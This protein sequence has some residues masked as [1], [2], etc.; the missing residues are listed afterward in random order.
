MKNQN[1]KGVLFSL[2]I[3]IVTLLLVDNWNSGKQL[4][5]TITKTIQAE[6][7]PK[8]DRVDLAFKQEFDKTKDPKLGHVPRERLLDAREFQLQKFL[9]KENYKGSANAKSISNI[10]WTERGPDNVGGRTR[11]IMFDPNDATNKKVWAGGVS[12]GLWYNDDITNVNSSWNKVNDFLDNLAITVIVSDPNDDQTFYAGTGE[13]HFVSSVRGAGI[14]KTTD[15]GDTWTHM[16]ADNSFYATD[17]WHYVNDIVVRN[18]SGTSVV[19]V[20]TQHSFEVEFTQRSG[21]NGLFRSTDGGVNFT[22]VLPNMPSK[23]YSYIPADIEL[24][25]SNRL[26][27][28][29]TKGIAL[30]PVEYSDGGD[31]LYSDDGTTWTLAL[32]TSDARVELACAPSDSDII[33]AVADDGTAAGNDCAWIKKCDNCSTDSDS[34]TDLTVPAYKTQGTCANSGTQDFT[35]GQA[36]Y[37][38]ILA[39]HPADADIAII[40]GI[41]LYRTTNGSTFS[42]ISYWTGSCDDEVHADQHAIVFRPGNSDEVVIGCDGGIYYS[43]DAGDNTANPDFTAHNDGYNVTQFYGTAIHPTSGTNHFLAGAQDN[44]S[45]KF[46]SSGVNST[47]EVSGGDGAFC[48][49][50]QSNAN[51]QFTQYVYNV[52][53]RSTNGGS[54]FTNVINDQST[55]QFI[56][57]TDYDNDAFILYG[58]SSA[59]NYFRWNDP[60]TGTSTST[61]SLSTLNGDQVSAVTVDPNTSNRVYFGSDGGK[62]IVVDDA[63]GTPS[64]T[65]ISGGSFS[66]YVS[67]IE[68]EDGDAN[69]LLVTFS[70]YGVTSVW[71]STDAGSNWIAIE[72]DLPDMPVRWGIFHPLNSDMAVLATELGIWTTDDINGAGTAWESTN[73][74]LSNVR[75]DM[76]QVRAADN[77]VIAATHGRGLFSSSSF[78]VTPSSDPV[79]YFSSAT[80]AITEI[81]ETASTGGDCRPYKDYTVTMIIASAPTGD[82]T[83]TLSSSITT[84]ADEWDDFVFTTNGDFTQAGKSSTLTFSDGATTSQTFTVR[85]YDDATVENTETIELEFAISGTTDATQHSSNTEHT[86]TLSD[87]DEVPTFAGSISLLSEDFEGGSLPSGWATSEVIT[88]ANDWRVGDLNALTGTYSAYVNWGSGGSPQDYKSTDDAQTFLITPQIDATSYTGM[89]FGFNYQCNGEFSSSTYWD[90]GLIAYSTDGSNFTQLGSEFQGVTTTTAYSI[91]LPSALD[92]TT[93]YLAFYWENDNNTAGQPAFVIDDVEVTATGTT[94]ASTLNYTSEQYLGPNETVLFFDDTN[95][96]IVAKIE[97]TSSHDYGCTTVTIDRSGTGTTEFWS[98]TGS[99]YLMDKTVFVTPTNNNSSG[100][101][102]ITLY[103]SDTEVNNWIAATSKATTDLKLA[104]TN[105]AVSTINSSSSSSVNA[106]LGSSNS[107]VDFGD[108]WAITSSFTTGFSG[109]GAGDP[110]PPPAPLPI[111]IVDL[112]AKLLDEDNVHVTWTSLTEENTDYILVQHSTDGQYFDVIGKVNAAGNS[113]ERIEYEFMHNNVN[114]GMHYYRLKTVD[115]DG[116]FELT[117][118]VSVLQGNSKFDIESIYPVPARDIINVNY[119]LDNTD[120][121]S[122]SLIDSRGQTVYNELLKNELGANHLEIACDYLP[123]GIYIITMANKGR[124]LR[125]RLVISK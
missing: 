72:G 120:I 122:I 90:Y 2:F 101:Y 89:T 67:H 91:S 60:R 83:V 43:A 3:A 55:G 76:L 6:K 41:D 92:G 49:I 125:E 111:E 102:T 80:N 15:G 50:D 30:S 114:Y 11:A 58:G 29:T 112:Y 68:V 8:R 23:T 45:H 108:G 104:K 56:N 52:Y 12:G 51:Y 32:S 123:N 40:G 48:H 84:D 85:I 88:S 87:N 62:V 115:I 7:I 37:D 25:A 69:H 10:S 81:T 53:Y 39:V 103:Y 24:S 97:N 14:F 96:E 46:T 38:L 54:S 16:T 18:E 17:D 57:P 100:T 99:E 110:G 42:T 94:I 31:I 119:T 1:F 117:N 118:V 109:I 13:G 20:A 22:Q 86:I 47:T 65:D 44:G 75:I 21:V 71:E 82:A 36:W 107:A 93:F 121:A 113:S 124:K 78:A 79:I 4:K 34:W 98:A 73:D 74:G 5:I 27:V 33:Y 77:E 95:D 64:A 19:Y 28:G 116:Q 35:R 61:V 70:S 66:G 105:V 26:F 63:D 106:E 59:D 9:T